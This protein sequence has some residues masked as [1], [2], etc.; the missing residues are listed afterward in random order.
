MAE[1][2]CSLLH[3]DSSE[4]LS[5]EA[6]LNCFDTMFR[7]PVPEDLRSC[8]LQDVIGFKDLSIYDA[9]L[10]WPLVLDNFV[11][12]DVVVLLEVVVDLG[13]RVL[14]IEVD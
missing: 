8:H 1:E 14:G 6:Q 4:G 10:A 3:S 11:G 13:F 5:R 2:I 7:G 9:D 12:G